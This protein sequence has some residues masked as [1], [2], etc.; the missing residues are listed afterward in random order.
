MIESGS[1]LRIFIGKWKIYKCNMQTLVSIQISLFNFNLHNNGHKTYFSYV[2]RTTINIIA[3]YI[4]CK[5]YQL[6][7][8]CHIS[9]CYIY[10][11][12][13]LILSYSLVPPHSQ[14]SF[15]LQIKFYFHRIYSYMILNT[16][17]K[18]KII[19]QRKTCNICL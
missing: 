17:I 8:H 15:L 3:V 18:F 4:S 7:G 2:Q 14:F 6:A 11:I 13:S 12:T 19:N 16:Y 9:M 10:S 5:R 1:V